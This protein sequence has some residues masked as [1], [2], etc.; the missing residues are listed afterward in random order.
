MDLAHFVSY[1]KGY[2]FELGKP[3]GPFI[4]NNIHALQVAEKLLKEI[5]FEMGDIWH[6]DLH[7]VL[8]EKGEYQGFNL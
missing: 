8:A 2:M 5:N 4:V 3:V 6:Y 1:K 7:G